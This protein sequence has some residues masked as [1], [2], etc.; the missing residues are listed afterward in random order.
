MYEQHGGPDKNWSYKGESTIELNASKAHLQPPVPVLFIHLAHG[1]TGW[2]VICSGVISYNKSKWQ[3]MMYIQKQNQLLF[4]W[5]VWLKHKIKEEAH[6]PHLTHLKQ[7][8]HCCI[9]IEPYMNDLPNNLHW[10]YSIKALKWDKF[11]PKIELTSELLWTYIQA[12][13][14]CKSSIRS[15]PG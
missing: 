13:L 11:L 6:W 8:F 1:I 14:L 10:N 12:I 7:N 2:N 4:F 9:C 15:I 3:A 5:W